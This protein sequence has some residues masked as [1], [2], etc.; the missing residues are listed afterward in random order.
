M[1]QFTIRLAQKVTTVEVVDVLVEATTPEEAKNLVF[2]AM[3][4]EDDDVSS[5]LLV[6]LDA[7]SVEIDADSD[8]WEFIAMVE[9]GTG[10]E[11]YS[12]EPVN[13]A[14][15]PPISGEVPYDEATN[16]SNGW[17]S[18]QEPGEPDCSGIEGSVA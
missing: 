16:P 10:I 5:P 18:P 6:A 4:D 17:E 14:N 15:V 11:G 2:A 12:S 8:G 7:N 3:E 9:P 13:L 1:P